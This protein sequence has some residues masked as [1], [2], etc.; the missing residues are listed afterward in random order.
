MTH[1]VTTVLAICM[2]LLSSSGEGTKIELGYAHFQTVKAASRPGAAQTML[3]GVVVRVTRQ[4]GGGESFVLTNE[5]GVELM[6][7]RP[8]DYCFDAYD[9]KGNALPLDPKQASCFPIIKGET[10]EVGVV[11]SAK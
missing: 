1:A 5:A 6:P 11:L 10:T 4:E 3:P 2:M 8:G 7:L 9:R